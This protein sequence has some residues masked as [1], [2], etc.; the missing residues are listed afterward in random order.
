MSDQPNQYTEEEISKILKQ[1]KRIF[2]GA[3]EEIQPYWDIKNSKQDACQKAIGNN[4][5]LGAYAIASDF[6]ENKT[7][8][9]I[10][11]HEEFKKINKLT[12]DGRCYPFANNETENVNELKRFF[13]QNESINS[14]IGFNSLSDNLLFHSS[15]TSEEVAI[16]LAHDW[17]PLATKNCLY[18]LPP[19]YK[20]EYQEH[21]YQKKKKN[22]DQDQKHRYIDFFPD[23]ELVKKYCWLYINL[24]PYFRADV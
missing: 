2:H 19:L 5:E 10:A 7:Q 4:K 21:R 20:D 6:L 3:K 1:Y 13:H 23:E 18:Y 14:G 8:D 16:I 15:E 9:Y 24:Y 12:L 22:Q 11:Y 17:Y